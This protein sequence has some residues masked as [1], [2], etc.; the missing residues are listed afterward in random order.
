MALS[1]G[2]LKG[3]EDD[4]HWTGADCLV[5]HSNESALVL[6]VYNAVEPGVKAIGAGLDLIANAAEHEKPVSPFKAWDRDGTVS[7][8]SRSSHT[9]T[10]RPERGSHNTAQ[11][12]VTPDKTPSRNSCCI[13]PRAQFRLCR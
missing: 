2:E 1:L 13:R 3:A 12:R 7:C 5:H 11:R 10:I 9:R 8:A 4:V 6:E